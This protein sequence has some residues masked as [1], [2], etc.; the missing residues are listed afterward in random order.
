MRIS[1]AILA[2]VAVVPATLASNNA[3]DNNAP[4]VVQKQDTGIVDSLRNVVMLKR[5]KVVQL[6]EE[7]IEEAAAKEEEETL[8]G[9]EVDQIIEG[10]IQ[11]EDGSVAVADKLV[12]GGGSDLDLISSILPFSLPPHISIPSDSFSQ[13]IFVHVA[14]ISVPAASISNAAFDVA[15]ASA[16][17]NSVYR[18]GVSSVASSFSLAN[19]V[20][21][22]QKSA[23]GIENRL[24]APSSTATPS[25]TFSFPSF[26]F[27]T[28]TFVIPAKAAAL[29]VFN[30]T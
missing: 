13:P 1:I 26:S 11:A 7:V 19:S 10:Q 21:A 14:S 29:R 6:E 27:P 5:S 3:I 30:F 17:K 22:V 25:A 20:S 23:S 4:L 8:T 28:F 16:P 2:I 24:G 18:V 9:E 15:S 12:V